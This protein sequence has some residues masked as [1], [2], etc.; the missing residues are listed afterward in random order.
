MYNVMYIHRVAGTFGYP[1][2]QTL[3]RPTGE[4]HCMLSHM[5]KCAG[6]IEGRGQTHKLLLFTLDT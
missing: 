2:T 1:L 3:N 6:H 5:R 4:Q